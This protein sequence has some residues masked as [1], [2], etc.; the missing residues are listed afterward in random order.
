VSDER[1]ANV[2]LVDDRA[3]NLLALEAVLQPLGQNL[4]K[5]TS[6]QEALKRLLQEDFAVILLD[7]QMPGLDGFGTAELIK[8]RQKTRDIPI[9]FLTA[10]SK[11]WHEVFRGYAVGAVDY[12]LKPFNPSVL[13]SKVAVFLELHEKNK[14]L[15]ESEQR[16]R[17]IIETT[18]EGVW[19]IDAESKTTFVNQKMA[20]MLG[21][22]VEEIMGASLFEFLDEEGKAIA[23]RNAER[24]RRGI[25]EEHDFKFRRNDGTDLWARLSSNPLF[26]ETGDYLGAL[27]MVT[28]ITER[29]RM[30]Q[31]LERAYS[32]LEHRA[33][34][35]RRSNADL[36]HFAYAASH[37]LSQPLTVVAGFAD[38]LERR[39]GGKLDAEADRFITGIREGIGRMQRLIDDLLIYARAGTRERVVEPVD[40]SMVLEETLETLAREIEESGATV[41]AGS[42]PTVPGDPVQL[43]QLFQNLV[44]NA[45]KYVAEGPPR[46]HVSAERDAEGWRFS[47]SDNGIGIDPGDAE[48]IF[49]MFERLHAAEEYAGTGIGL[50]VCKRIV[51]RH[52]GRIWVEG[53]PD[54]G[55]RFCF[56]IAGALPAP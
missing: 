54:G 47:V 19:T 48:K 35:L 12:V 20:E 10:I 4:V 42:L 53:E 3:E 52:T 11:E 38:I 45:I 22:T 40:C 31:D 6:G 36:E 34:E 5:A 27:A 17:R 32:E 25:A 13:R 1:K 55:S 33:E 21:Y 41:T 56:T 7:V 14:A 15:E 30:E 2:L 8:Q 23:E 44:G 18:L 16:Y 51:E 46:V 43:G 49:E 28:D 37:D 50:A 24:R 9:I 26:D 29:K 39:Y